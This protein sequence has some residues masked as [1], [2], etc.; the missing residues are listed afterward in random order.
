L[1]DE[2]PKRD[3]DATEEDREQEDRAVIFARRRLLVTTAMAGIATS[4]EACDWLHEKLAGSSPCLQVTRPSVC[5][6]APSVCLEIAPAT[7]PQPCLTPQACLRVIRVPEDAAAAMPCLSEARVEPPADRPQAPPRRGPPPRPR[8]PPPRPCLEMASPHV[9]LS[10][11][12]LKG[13]DEDE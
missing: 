4:V 8:R 10:D 12:T 3:E 1:V 6:S 5:L 2:D 13:G 11:D 9:C 7:P